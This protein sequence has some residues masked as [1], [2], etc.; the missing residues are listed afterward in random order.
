[1]LMRLL[2]DRWVH[3]FVLLAM[4]AA[5]VSVRVYDS[6]KDGALV[7]GL[8]Y[9]AFDAYNKWKPRPPTDQ[10]VMVDIDESSLGRPE[11]GQWPWSRDTVA[12]M[13]SNLHAMGARAI[14]F[15]MVFPEADRTSP[16]AILE[17]ITPEQ[18][19]PEFQTLLSAMPDNDQKLAD[20]ITA[21]GNVVLGFT[22]TTRSGSTARAPHQAKAIGLKGIAHD[23]LIPEPEVARFAADGTELPVSPDSPQAQDHGLRKRWVHTLNA[24]ATSLPLLSKAAAGSGSFHVVPELDG[25]IRRVP[26]LALYP[27]EGT[28]QMILYPSLGVEA[29]RVAQ[30]AKT[31]IRIRPVS[32]KEAGVFAPPL[33]MSVGKYE[34][35]IDWDGKFYIYVTKAQPK[36]YIPAWKVINNEIETDKIA[37]KIVFIGTSAAGLKDIRSIPGNLYVPGVELHMNLVG[38]VLT[39][40]YLNRAAEVTEG[41]ELMAVVA[42]GTLI[43]ALAPFVGAVYMTIFTLMLTFTIFAVSWYGFDQH[44][45]LIDPIYPTICILVIFVAATIL[46]YVRTEY[47]RSRVR[48][49][50]GLYISPDFME[51]LTKDPDK[52]KLGGETRELT[53]MF[54][55]IRGFTTISESMSPEALTQLMNSFLTPMSDLVMETRGTI[56]KYMGD[57]MMA[58]WN[59]PLDDE[60]HARHACTAALR[61]Y[62]ALAPVNEELKIRAQAERRTPVVLNAGIGIN[63]GTA[64]V[65]N[66]GSRQRFAYSA[67]G[68]TVNLASRLE[69]Q[70][71][72]YGVNILISEAT[73]SHVP[74]F[75]CLELDLIRVKG[76]NEPVRIFTLVGEG[77]MAAAAP[78]RQWH[79]RHTQMMAAYRAMAFDDALRLIAECRTLSGGAL[80][81]FYAVFAARIGDLKTE[82]PA[83]GWDGVYVATSK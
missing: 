42:L 26:L 49:A 5:A 16:A 66:M 7:R 9:V 22:E 83:E 77:E 43:I 32:G 18:R 37:G 65:G 19:T 80:D 73:A 28:D 11:L 6:K 68:D 50:F 47:E 62:E 29:L 79:E 41:A 44:G 59:A 71:K 61:M 21:A 46:A 76:K 17:R 20:A 8:S 58:F 35:P 36:N 78:F 64:S 31:L 51:E 53:V 30:G 39:G 10:V 33:L 75:A 25:I 12:R 45:L 27:V 72:A 56:D 24:V 57:A 15:D 3:T 52:L 60:E 14:V 4:L 2:T 81:G 54:T 34:I 13:V 69:G 1:M 82:R 74:D 67:L 55:D 70:T 40:E 63:T 48:Q 38:Q 23:L